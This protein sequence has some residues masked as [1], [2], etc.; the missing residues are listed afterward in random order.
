[1]LHGARG[2]ILCL[3]AQGFKGSAGQLDARQADGGEGRQGE[4]CEVDVVE[5]ND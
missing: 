2:A 4:L 1:M 5:T 3:L